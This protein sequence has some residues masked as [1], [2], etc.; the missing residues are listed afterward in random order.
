MSLDWSLRGRTAGQ[1]RFSPGKARIRLNR[2]LLDFPENGFH[3]LYD[4]LAH[5]L[6]HVVASVISPKS[7]PHGPI[8]Q[9]IAVFFGAIPKASHQLPLLAVRRSREYRYRMTGCREI[10]LGPLRHKRLQSGRSQYIDRSSGLVIQAH[11][12][13]GEWR[14]KG[15]DLIMKL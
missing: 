3:E 9:E 13:C 6:A 1:V 14:W 11:A 12:F 4:T 2:K 7:K 8:W 5:E 15:T 10:W